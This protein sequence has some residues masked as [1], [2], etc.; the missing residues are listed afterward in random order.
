VR[1]FLRR[2]ALFNRRERVREQWL[3]EV[4][5]TLGRGFIPDFAPKGT[6]GDDLQGVGHATSIRTDPATLVVAR[7]LAQRFGGQMARDQVPVR[8]WQGTIPEA[9]V[10]LVQAAGGHVVFFGPPL[11]E[12]FM[13][14]YRTKVRQEDAA[15]FARQAREW[16]ACVVRTAFT[17]SDDDLP[18]LWHLRPE[19]VAE[20]T[21]AVALTWLETCDAAR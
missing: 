5:P 16:G 12:A 4:L 13:E 7:E 8:E 11:S 9:L 2:L 17:Y 19:R 1:V 15:L 20:Y 6:L 21:R 10:R 3:D 14:G 18:D